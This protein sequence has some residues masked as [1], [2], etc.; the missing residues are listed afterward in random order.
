METIGLLEIFVKY[1]FEGTFFLEKLIRIHDYFKKFENNFFLFNY[2]NYI[3]ANNKVNFNC[4]NDELNIKIK[5]K[6]NELIKEITFPLDKLN[7]NKE[8]KYDKEKI[9]V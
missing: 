6:V 3:F 8:R 5:F 9:L 7:M 2:Y 1:S 4:K